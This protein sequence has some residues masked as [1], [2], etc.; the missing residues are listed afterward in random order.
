MNYIKKLI[1]LIGMCQY[2]HIVVEFWG[3]LRFDCLKELAWPNAFTKGEAKEIVREIRELGMEPIPMFNMLGHASASR[4]WFGKHV[5]LDQNPRLQPLFSPDG[6]VWDITSQKVRNLQRQIRKELY[7]LFGDTEY[8][9]IG[10]DEAYYAAHCDEIV[11]ALPDYLRDLT[12][13]VAAEGRKP[14]IWMDMFL[15]KNQLPEIYVR[16]CTAGESEKLISSLAM[17][18]VM[19]DWQYDVKQAPVE[20]LLL[21]KDKGHELLGAPWLD[22]ENFGAYIDTISE[23]KLSGIML[24]TWHTLKNQMCNILRCAHKCGAETFWWSA[25]SGG[26]DG[27]NEETASLLRRVSFEGNSYAACGWIEQQIEL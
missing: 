6:W 10:C 26:P 21:L 18:T 4:N 25:Q 8:F 15:E 23:H 7:D 1:R 17:E 13:E 9:H 19:V 20:S 22:P 11:N 5:V 14:M 24:T 2:T 12:C 3:T 16:N 27:P